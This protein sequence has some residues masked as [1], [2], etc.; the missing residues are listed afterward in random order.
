MRG[1]STILE[2]LYGGS[3]LSK[4]TL[5]TA[6]IKLDF[7]KLSEDDGVLGNRDPHLVPKDEMGW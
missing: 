7:P 2:K 6:A 1:E 5:G 4:V 3:Y